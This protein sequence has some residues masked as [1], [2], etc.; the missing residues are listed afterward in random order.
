MRHFFL[1][2]ALIGAMTLHAEPAWEDS[3][4]D[5]LAKAEKEKKMVLVMLTQ[6]GCDACWYMENIVFDDD[7]LVDGVSK[8]FVWV[9]IDVNDDRIPDGLRYF[10][11]PT[12]H[13]L[14]SGGKK[15]YKLDGGANIQDFRKEV[16]AA[17]KAGGR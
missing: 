5:A 10:G 14:S 16:E 8:D 7:E 9:K 4:S 17:K 13:F 1:I 15:L 6:R 12:F 3:Y 11:T 2:F